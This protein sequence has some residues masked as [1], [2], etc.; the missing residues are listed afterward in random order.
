MDD[1]IAVYEKVLNHELKKF[2]MNFW[3][4]DEGKKRAIKITRYLL[5]D[6]LKYKDNEIKSKIDYDFFIKHKLRGMVQRCYGSHFLLLAE[7]YPH[8]NSWEYKELPKN[9]WSEE[10]NVREA[11]ERLFYKE[12]NWTYQDILNNSN[13]EIFKDN[14]LE[15]LLQ[16]YGGSPYK[17]LKVLFPNL[18]VWELKGYHCQYDYWN[19]KTI[20]DALDWLFVEKLNWSI[21]DIK[22]KTTRSI[23]K[24]NELLVVL[25]GYFKDSTKKVVEFYLGKNG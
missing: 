18:K 7:V 19:E 14:G 6:I 4:G 24:E 20:R 3:N 11:L 25:H 1:S 22:E 9:F 17:T 21:N 16:V 23:F 13:A 10:R 8:I 5:E 12:L 15:G 2:P